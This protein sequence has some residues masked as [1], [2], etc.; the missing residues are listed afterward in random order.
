MCVR[1]ILHGQNGIRKPYQTGQA[2]QSRKSRK[3]IKQITTMKNFK[4]FYSIIAIVGIITGVTFTSCKSGKQAISAQQPKGSTSPFAGGAYEAPCA[5]Y[6]DEQNFGATGIASGSAAQKG[7]LQQVALKNAQDLVAMKMQHAVE[8]EVKSFF[9]SV[10][11]NQGT[12]VE[13]QTI[14]GINSIILGI[15]NNTSASCLMYSGVNDKGNVEC[16]VGIKVSKSQVANS[17]ADNLSKNQKEDIR[18]RAEDFRKQLQEDLKAY[19]G[20]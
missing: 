1:K 9:E 13:N 3:L 20:E 5:V 10:G 16:Y 15:A 17:V 11:A 18:K 12:D 19:K 4:I 8:G 6:D 2:L 7:T 14:G